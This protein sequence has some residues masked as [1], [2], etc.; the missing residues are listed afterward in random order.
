MRIPVVAAF[1]LVAVAVLALSGLARAADLRVVALAPTEDVSLP[2]WCDWGYDWEDRCYRDDSD[3]LG[4]GGVDDKVWRAA[5]R[6]SFGSLPRSA[7]VVTAELSLWYDRT[8]VAP[9][10]R[11]VACDGRGFDFEAHPIF[12]QR[13]SA[14]RDVELGPT[15]ATASL[16]PLAPPGWVVWDLTDLVSDWRS[17]GL[18]NDGV[19]LEFA[20]AEE[21]FG[22][23]G[24]SFPSSSY[25]DATLRPRLT[26]WYLPG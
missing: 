25:A 15:V 16:D 18:E 6:F 2:F 12:T 10:R 3:R 19:L 4:A 22:A 26:V 11:R 9:F 14:E 5:L 8:C 13:W 20:D 23:S 1:V 24:P 21:D 17:G 7:I